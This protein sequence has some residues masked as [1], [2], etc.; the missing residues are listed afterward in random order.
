MTW[1]AGK[2]NQAKKR[3]HALGMDKSNECHVFITLDNG[4]D[5]D[6][7]ASNEEEAQHTVKHDYPTHN[8]VMYVT[9]EA[10]MNFSNTDIN[11]TIEKWR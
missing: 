2:L 5:I 6:F 1:D 8:L 4:S 3:L 7:Y 9:D 10:S 11:I